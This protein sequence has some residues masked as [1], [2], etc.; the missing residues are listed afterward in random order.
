[1]TSVVCGYDYFI[2][3]IEELLLY[4]N[5]NLQE[6]NLLLLLG[7]LYIFL[8]DS[9]SSNPSTFTIFIQ[10]FVTSLPKSGGALSCRRHIRTCVATGL[11]SK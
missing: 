11:S 9:I 8:A 10:N 7:S 1:M 2:V 3:L 5:G 6:H 4:T